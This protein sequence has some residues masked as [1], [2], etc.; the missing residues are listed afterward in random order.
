MYSEDDYIQL[1]AL[2]HFIFCP[3]QCALIHVEQLWEENRLTAEGRVTH[4]RVHDE[5]VEKRKGVNIERGV[6]LCSK[7][8]GLIGKADIVEFRHTSAGTEVFPVEYKHGKPKVDDC[9]KVQLCAQAICLEEMLGGKIERGAI[10]YGK[11]RRRLD[12]E[13]DCALR[14]VTS[15]TA[16]RLHGLIKS[17]KTPPPEYA[18]RCENCSLVDMCMPKAMG[19]RKVERYIS[20]MVEGY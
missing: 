7:Q 2:Q 15:D 3:R 20:D 17:G 10:F 4:E 9:D 5:G 19:G 13:F 6:S 11:I 12:V 14:K 18:K 8:L 16:R 1:A